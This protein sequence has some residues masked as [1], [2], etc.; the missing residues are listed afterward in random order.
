[1]QPDESF[2]KESLAEARQALQESEVPIGCLALHEGLIIARAHNQREAWQDP[3][4]HAE[5]IVLRE[6]ARKLG[7]WRLTGVTLYVTVEPC[8]MCAG[9]LVMARIDRLVYGCTDP[10]AGACGSVFDILRDPRLN[11]RL[12]MN[13]GVLETECQAILKDF[14]A[15]RR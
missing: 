7:R 13:G 6:A 11:H 14:F 1:M 10:K 12:E 15:K 4:A 5:I 2:M 3:T 8:A 9:A